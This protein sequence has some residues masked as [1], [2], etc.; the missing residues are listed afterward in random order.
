MDTDVECWIHI[1]VDHRRYA[2]GIHDRVMEFT[3]EPTESDIASKV[4]D[5]RS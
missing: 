4:E 1:D 3:G 2:F 5:L